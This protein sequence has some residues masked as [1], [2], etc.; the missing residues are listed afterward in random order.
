MAVLLCTPA[1]L[2]WTSRSQRIQ[3]YQ[4]VLGPYGHGV[5]KLA[6]H[7]PLVHIPVDQVQN[8]QANLAV[9]LAKEGADIEQSIHTALEA[10]LD[11]TVEMADKPS[12]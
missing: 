8:F 10:N 9:L 7:P 4:T 3:Q 1:W 12:S 5:V 2:S 11:I 6:E